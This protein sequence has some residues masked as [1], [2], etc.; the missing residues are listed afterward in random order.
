[1]SGAK[2]HILTCIN[3]PMGCTIT[4]KA[5]GSKVLSVDGNECKAGE[6]YAILEMEHPMRIL[7]STVKVKNGILSRIPVRSSAELPKGNIRE[8]VRLL[9]DLEVNAPIDIHSPVLK[10]LLGTGVD[11]ITTRSME[12]DGE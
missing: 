2:E 3:C 10:D 1:M 9:N 7:T 12:R 8:C 11:I 4:V 6:K 5:K